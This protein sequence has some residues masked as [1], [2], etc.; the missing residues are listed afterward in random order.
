MKHIMDHVGI[1]ITENN[2]RQPYKRILH[3]TLP[4]YIPTNPQQLCKDMSI[5]QILFLPIEMDIFQS[6]RTNYHVGYRYLFSTAGHDTISLSRDPSIG[7]ITKLQVTSSVQ[8]FRY[9][10]K[11]DIDIEVDKICDP[12]YP[13][14]IFNIEIPTSEVSTYTFQLINDKIAQL[15]QWYIDKNV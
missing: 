11:D 15:N 6:D 14:F 12:L 4:N 10:I 5:D 13:P 9:I 2:S 7:G 8:R 3:G 1:Y